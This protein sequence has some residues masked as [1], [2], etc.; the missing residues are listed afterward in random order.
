M[1]QSTYLINNIRKGKDLASS[2]Y[3]GPLVYPMG[4]IVIALVSLSVGPSVFKCLGNRSLD[5]SEILHE[6]GSQ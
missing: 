3:I 6:L 5:F 1:N 4:S 2:E